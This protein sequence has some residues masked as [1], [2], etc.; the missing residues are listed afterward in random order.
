VSVFGIRS[1]LRRRPYSADVPRVPLL[2][3]PGVAVVNLPDGAVVLRPPRPRE[4]LEDVGAAVRDALRFPLAGQPLRGLVRA[5]NRA[6]IVIEL[7]NLPIPGAV[8]D[9]RQRAVESV[10]EELERLGVPTERQT[11]LVAGGL[12]RRAGQKELPLLVSPEFARRFRGQLVI[13]DV[14]DPALV[15]IGYAGR[16]PL[17]VNP[18]LV[19]TDAVVVVTA[20]ETVLHGGA[21]ALLAAGS[22]HALRAAG[23]W[24][25]LQPPA[26]FGWRLAIE[27]EAALSDRVPLI[28]VSLVLNH[29]RLL[30]ATLRDFPFDDGAVAA[31]ANSPLRRVLAVLPSPVRAAALRRLR[32]ELTAASAF[33]GP[34]SIAHTEALLRSIE[35]RQTVLEGQLE[36]LVVGIPPTT[37]TIPRERPNPLLAAYLALGLAMRFWRED[38]PIA[39]GGTLILLHPFRRRF[40][41]PSQMP[42]RTFFGALRFGREAGELAQA[43]S[44]AAAD[45]RALDAYRSGRA[46]H[47]LLPFADWAA[48][49]PALSH[50]GAVLVAGCRDHDA[51]RLLGLVP[52]HSVGAAL[53]IARGRSNGKGSVGALLAPPY[54]PLRVAV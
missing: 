3:G 40:G 37:P 4:V 7:P 6:T 36:T 23:A 43:E 30:A 32:R 10:S 44:A 16:V 14:E 21:A 18:A 34:P 28:G 9:P 51:A 53:E 12:A 46:A 41:H 48:C 50:L 42:Y 8:S 31:V 33:A 54:F 2:A 38:F 35:A 5:G 22:T 20:A 1:S 11:L 26:S 25:L 17:R 49:G 52:V 19:E 15:E 45:P 13:H 27:T 47:P 39:E 24:S 29:P